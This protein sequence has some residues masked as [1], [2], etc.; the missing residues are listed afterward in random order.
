V[1][2]YT[3]KG[4][5]IPFVN[6]VKYLGVIFDKRIASRYLIEMMEAE[7]FR[8]FIKLCSLFRSE[9]LS[10]NIKLTLHKALFRSVMAYAS[11][12]WEFAA[13]THLLKLQH[14]ENKVLRTVENFP[15]R[16]PAS[17]C[18]RISTF[19]MCTII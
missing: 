12:A 6:Q 8:T 5:N 14:L 2:H 1:A 18:T 15:R 7:A 13:D 4:R 10:A 11:L 9:R 19:R 17:I 3:L 16:S